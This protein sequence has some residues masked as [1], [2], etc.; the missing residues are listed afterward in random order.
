MADI[1]SNDE[2]PSFQPSR[3]R[4]RNVL[5]EA[6]SMIG[7]GGLG[8]RSTSRSNSNTQSP[9]SDISERAHD[10]NSALDI[11]DQ[12]FLPSH[13]RSL[14]G[15]A[16]RAFLLGLSFTLSLLTTL[17]ILYNTTSP[18]WRAPFF[19]TTLS[20]FHFLEFYITALANT[21][22][23]TV[24]SFLL[25]SNGAAYNIAHTVAFTECILSNYFLRYD[26]LPSWI[27]NV[28]LILGLVLI[29]AG[30]ICRS[31]AMYQAGTNFSHLVKHTK[32]PTHTL[33]TSGVYSHLRHPSYFG[34]FWWGIGTQVVS[35]NVLSLVGYAVVLWLFFSR[36]IR[37]EEESLVRFFG[38]EYLTYRKTTGVGIPF[39]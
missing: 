21:A 23:A 12:Q 29:T 19:I 37:G 31:L 26:I 39:I 24:A 33:I 3:V 11:Y 13:Q 17:Y 7:S 35:G 22:D 30:Q 36:R 16:L 18:L 8:N 5:N 34:F 2:S 28:N 25:T 4:Q 6:A 15:I 10:I 20:L 27:Q 14:S 1:P 9:S 38:D 32:A